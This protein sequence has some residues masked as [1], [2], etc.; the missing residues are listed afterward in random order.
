MVIFRGILLL[1]QSIDFLS[2]TWSMVVLCAKTILFAFDAYV[3]R[4]RPSDMRAMLRKDFTGL[5][6]LP[7]IVDTVEEASSS[8]W[9]GEG[10]IMND[11]KDLGGLL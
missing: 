9:S 4:A 6:M 2:F 11:S 8:L 5:K 3:D 10:I 7:R 1:L